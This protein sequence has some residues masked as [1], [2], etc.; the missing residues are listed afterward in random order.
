M[1]NL[2]FKWHHKAYNT[3]QLIIRKIVSLQTSVNKTLGK[4]LQYKP[5][6]QSV[7]PE[8]GQIQQSPH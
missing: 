2:K 7:C 6:S 8:R 1:L 3:R 4:C 5:H